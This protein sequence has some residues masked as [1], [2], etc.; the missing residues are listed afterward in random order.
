MARLNWNQV[1]D[2]LYEV[3]V[4][5]GVF[6]PTV[7]DGVPWNGLVSIKEVPEGVEGSDI[8]LDGVKQQKRTFSESFAGSIEAFTYPEEFAEYDG[9]DDI[10]PGG[11]LGQ[12]TRKK[13]NLSYRSRVGN[14]IEGV[15]HGYKLHLVYNALVSP[16]GKDN[17][18]LQD[19]V[20]VLLFNWSFTTLPVAFAAGIFGS[21]LVIDTRFVSESALQVLEDMLYGTDT[22]S[23][24][25][26][27]VEEIF[28]IFEDAAILKITDHGDGTWTAD[29]PDSAIIMLDS[30]TFQI[31][32]PSAIFIDDISYHISS[33]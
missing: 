31:T 27:T 11:F 6:Y 22:T 15:D 26:P 10:S 4:D 3:G 32:W 29:G 9:Q 24:H 23:P 1:G 8:Y 5:R 17:S 18:S 28:T 21:H 20:G 13:F 33:L 30:T 19:T 2:S 25:F 14:D 16:S 12:S 7:G